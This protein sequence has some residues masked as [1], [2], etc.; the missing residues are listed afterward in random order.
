[1]RLPGPAKLTRSTRRGSRVPQI[2]QAAPPV[3]PSL[4]NT[5]TQT[6][7]ALYNSDSC[8]F[9]ARVRQAIQQLGLEI[10]IRDAAGNAVRRAELVEGGGKYQVPCLRIEDAQGQVRWMYESADIC[11]Y[12]ETLPA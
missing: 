5:M 2:E 8:W 3:A 10:E 4:E 7:L 12:L 1:M 9:C 6:K 11:H